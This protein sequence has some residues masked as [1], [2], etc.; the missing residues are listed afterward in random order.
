MNTT[1]SFSYD[2]REPVDIVIPKT[3]AQVPVKDRF[4]RNEKTTLASYRTMYNVNCA[5]VE[6]CKRMSILNLATCRIAVMLDA[7]QQYE[8]AYISQP[9]YLQDHHP[10]MHHVRKA[11][12]EMFHAVVDI[13]RS[14][15]A[16]EVDLWFRYVDNVLTVHYF[17]TAPNEVTHA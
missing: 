14:Y 17:I 7:S 15:R 10:A 16:Y 2:L 13:V 11:E 5:L 6:Y 4:G 3:L 8:L 12:Q 1:F 9:T